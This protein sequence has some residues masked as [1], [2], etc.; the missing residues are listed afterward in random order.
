MNRFILLG[1]VSRRF[2]YS[3][4]FL[5][6]GCDQ[7][8][9]VDFMIR[10]QEV[11]IS[12]SRLSSLS[13]ITQICAELSHCDSKYASKVNVESTFDPRLDLLNKLRA[14]NK[15]LVQALNS[16]D[17]YLNSDYSEL[18]KLYL[19]NSRESGGCDSHSSA[20]QRCSES[21]SNSS[22]G[23]CGRERSSSE[24]REERKSEKDVRVL[25]DWEQISEEEK[26]DLVYLGGSKKYEQVRT[27][28][29]IALKLRLSS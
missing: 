26:F 15:P 23:T 4:K 10:L 22:A 29:A 9:E 7:K 24:D 12:S 16:V 6:V 28:Y 13:S 8:F 11:L 21:S 25:K 1:Y 19:L 17:E 27:Y 18:E 20:E 14:E 2:Q 3:G 5:R